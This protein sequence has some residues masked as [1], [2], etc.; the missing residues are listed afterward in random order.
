IRATLLAG[1][2]SRHQRVCI[3]RAVEGY[4]LSHGDPHTLWSVGVAQIPT[5]VDHPHRAGSG[6]VGE[7]GATVDA[8]LKPDAPAVAASAPEGCEHSDDYRQL[9]NRSLHKT[10]ASFGFDPLSAV[11]PQGLASLVA[12]AFSRSTRLRI[13]PLAVFGKASINRIVRGAL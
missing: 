8:R 4:L 2:E 6:H 5:K 10:P 1:R 11:G 9:T 13:F 12:A 3:E 7:A